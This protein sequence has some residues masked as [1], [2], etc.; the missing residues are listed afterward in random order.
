MTRPAT[1]DHLAKSKS[2][3]RVAFPII[4]D[5]GVSTICTCGWVSKASSRE[6]VR[7][8]RAEAHLKKNHGGNGAWM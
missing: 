8:D 6:K 5:T 1:Q 4:R 7:G 2:R 3:K